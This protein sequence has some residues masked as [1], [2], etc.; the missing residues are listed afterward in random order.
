MVP[1]A[2]LRFS[3]RI[4][5]ETFRRVHMPSSVIII[6]PK[7]TPF[8][9]KWACAPCDRWGLPGRSMASDVQLA[10]HL[11]ENMTDCCLMPTH[12]RRNTQL[13]WSSSHSRLAPDTRIVGL[14][15]GP[16]TLEDCLKFGR[17]L[18][19]AISEW[20]SRPLL[21]ISSDMNHFDSDE[22]NRQLDEAALRAMET[23]NPEEL[24]YG[25]DSAQTSA[26]VDCG[27]L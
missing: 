18:A 1:H 9:A 16:A 11:V 21:V 17:Q 8:G 15:I 13:R 12:M 26:C 27:R 22:E 3:G 2:G 19:A 24:Y 20:N 25:C 10:E 7:H 23:C 14:A 5:A 6:G 4:A